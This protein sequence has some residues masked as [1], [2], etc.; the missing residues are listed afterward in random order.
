MNF[1]NLNINYANISTHHTGRRKWKIEIT[2]KVPAVP[3]WNCADVAGVVAKHLVRCTNS[4]QAG[5]KK[6]KF[7]STKFAYAQYLL[8]IS[9][10]LIRAAA[11]SRCGKF[12][13][14]VK[15]ECKDFKI[16]SRHRKDLIEIDFIPV[17][18]RRGWRWCVSTRHA[19]D[20]VASTCHDGL[21]KYG[22]LAA[23]CRSERTRRQLASTK[24][25]RGPA[26]M[27]P[28]SGLQRSQK[29]KQED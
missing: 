14:E 19:A 8:Y 5:R 28:V 9:Q 13:R 1:T 12:P 15:S 11:A 29:W 20:R 26:L 16:F 25:T 17:W 18:W 7:A 27:Q 4:V 24:T 10:C 23:P 3:V 2:G 6:K 21:K 22:E